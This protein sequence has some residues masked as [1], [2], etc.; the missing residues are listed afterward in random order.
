[1]EDAQVHPLWKCVFYI[2]KTVLKMDVVTV[3]TY[4]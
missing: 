4:F 3:P 2:P 1:M